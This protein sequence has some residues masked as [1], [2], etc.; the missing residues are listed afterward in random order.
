MPKKRSN[1]CGSA[2]FEAYYAALFEDRWPVLK[3]SLLAPA[4][5]VAF[6]SGLLKPYYLDAGSVTAAEAL[7]VLGAR[8]VLDLCAAPGGKTLV[9]AS[10]LDGDAVLTANERSRDRRM[11]L[12]RVLDE[13]VPPPLR[14]RITVCGRDAALWAKYERD[15]YDRILVDAPCSSERHVLASPVFLDQWTPARIRNLASVQWAILSS[16]FLVLK[17]GG[18][19][20]YATCALSPSENDGVVSRLLKK[21]PNAQ[22]VQPAVPDTHQGEP[23]EY[24]M[25][26]LPDMAGGAGPMYFSLIQKALLD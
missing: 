22:T 12:V 1:V 4:R 8:R 17:P 13:H 21:Y 2:A 25:H 7:P 16:A 15:A 19:L 18:L 11:R 14:E 20:L 26:I 9:T 3:E 6:D 5:S 23:T 10:R 24:G